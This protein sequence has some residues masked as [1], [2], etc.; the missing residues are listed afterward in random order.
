MR[1]YRI[2]MFFEMDLILSK[3]FK[4]PM[5]WEAIQDVHKERERRRNTSK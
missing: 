1:S 2:R 4:T 5:Q 3:A